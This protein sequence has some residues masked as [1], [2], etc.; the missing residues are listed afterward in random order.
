MVLEMGPEVAPDCTPVHYR[1]MFISAWEAESRLTL[2]T[3]A[4]VTGITEAGV[5]YTDADGNAQF[6]SADSVVLSVGM[7]SN[8][9]EAIAFHAS[10]DQFRM[11][12]DCMKPG[13]IQKCTRAAYGIA[14]QI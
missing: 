14:S 1:S 5:S 6:I 8:T 2:R 9:D 3:N 12:G 4:K 10:A 11:F 13:N 7:V